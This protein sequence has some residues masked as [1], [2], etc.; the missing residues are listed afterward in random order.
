MTRVTITLRQADLEKV[1][2][3]AERLTIPR[4]AL[5]R[6]MVVEGMEKREPPKPD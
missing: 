1:D 5:I 3:L 2:Q 6:I 4:S